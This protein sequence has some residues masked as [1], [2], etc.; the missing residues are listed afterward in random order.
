MTNLLDTL[1]AVPTVSGGEKSI[2]DKIYRYIKNYV[3]ESQIDALGNLICVRKALPKKGKKPLKI[4]F[5]CAVDAPGRI[6]TY[7]EENGLVRTA[8]IGKTDLKFAAY[9]KVVTADEK[10][11]GILVPENFKAEKDAV[12]EPLFADFGFENESE[13]AE[14]ISVGDLLCFA[15]EPVRLPSKTGKTVY[16]PALGNKLCVA[17][18]AELA[19]KTE[20][21]DAFELSFAF[22]AQSALGARGAAPAAFSLTPDIAVCFEPYE[23]KT[24]G[25][26]IADRFL[27]SY[28]TFVKDLTDAAAQIGMTL[29]PQIDSEPLFTDAARIGG[30]GQGVRTVTLLYP[31]NAK[32]SARERADVTLCG[33]FTELLL[34]FLRQL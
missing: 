27:V 5:F 33:K 14:H 13:A 3:N 21:N 34:Q 29:T 24:P 10:Y 25:I 6:V 9:S 30:A 20:P 26:R 2:N 32:G 12:S 22:C 11:T 17:V 23:G 4:G 15:D 16:A 18:L 8:A 19:H 7:I 28:G 31:V 1:L